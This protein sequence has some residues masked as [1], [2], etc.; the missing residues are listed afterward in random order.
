[1]AQI[2]TNK[3]TFAKLTE[4]AWQLRGDEF[5]S[6]LINCFTDKNKTNLLCLSTDA[7]ILFSSGGMTKVSESTPTINAVCKMP[8]VGFTPL[9]VALN[10]DR[11]RS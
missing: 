2:F 7:R 4:L 1:M 5:D 10:R 8:F 9:T 11:N 6:P 3:L